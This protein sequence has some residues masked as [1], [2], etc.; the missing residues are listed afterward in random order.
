MSDWLLPI[1]QDDFK[2]AL[3]KVDIRLVTAT[4]KRLDAEVEA[5][6]FRA[7]LRARMLGLQLVLLPLRERRED[8]A[9]I[10][11]ALLDKL[12]PGRDVAFS[13]DAIAALY[14]HTW[15]L[16]IRAGLL[17]PLP[18]GGFPLHQLLGLNSVARSGARG[19]RPFKRTAN[20]ALGS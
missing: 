8:L 17:H 11:I 19:V 15:P 10:A 14:A 2:K 12:A 4:H 9:V 20:V 1:I 18:F 5:G 16:N 7:D 6:R 13:A 3:A